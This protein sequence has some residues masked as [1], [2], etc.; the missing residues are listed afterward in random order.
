MAEARTVGIGL[1]GTGFMGGVHARAYRSAPWIFP[2]AAAQPEIRVVADLRLEDARAFAERF[3]IPEWTDDWRTLLD[4]AD[5]AVVDITTPPA[6]HQRIATA[7]AAAGKHVYCEKPVGRG[8]DETT[9]IWEAVREAG[10]ASFVGFNFRLAPAVLLAHEIVSGGRIG[11]LRQVKVSFRSNYDYDPDHPTPWRWRFGREEAGAGALAD[12]GSHTFDLA[13]HLGGPIARVCGMTSITVPERA[14]PDPAA[15]GA[16]RVVDND[17]SF[18]ALVHFA[19]GATG[20]VEGSRVAIGSRGDLRF[21]VVGSHGAVRWRMPR[22]NELQVCFAATPE[23]EQGFTTIQTGPAN[24]PFGQFIPSPLGLGYADTKVIEVHRM[25]EA[26]AKGETISP[27]LDDM[28]A[29]ARLI[30]AVQRGG[31]VEIPE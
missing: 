18:A 9:A 16:T 12:L 1:I 15:R 8:L 22:M 3:G 6:L 20:I 10:V 2:E 5:V 13:R 21:E 11:R 31:W 29:V 19:N 30:D 24:P 28:L 25:V 26:V 17:D 23:A 14:D 27:N 4:R 7:A